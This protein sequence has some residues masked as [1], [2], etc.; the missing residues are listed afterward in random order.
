MIDLEVVLPAILYICLIVF[1]IVL[2][3]FIIK[4][5]KTLNKVDDILEDCNRKLI[6]LDGV[7]NLID[8]ATDYASGLSDKIVNAISNGI[9]ALF[10]RK[11]G[12]KDDEQM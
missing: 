8:S 11:K 5:H 9:N 3:S 2:I 4:L 6:K 12:R 10:R 7:F 1:V